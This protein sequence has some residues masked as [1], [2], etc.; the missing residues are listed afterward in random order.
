[1]LSISFPLPS[2]LSLYIEQLPRH[3]EYKQADPNEKANVKSRCTQ[4]IPLAEEVKSR[5]KARYEREY[6]AYLEEKVYNSYWHLYYLFI[7]YWPL[8]DAESIR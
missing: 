5:I 3:A 8:F 1:M 4:L 6:E 7:Y 2:L